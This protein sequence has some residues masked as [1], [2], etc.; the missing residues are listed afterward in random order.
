MSAEVPAWAVF[1]FALGQFGP[2]AIPALLVASAL[3]ISRYWHRCK[4]HNAAVRRALRAHS[5][6]SSGGDPL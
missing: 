5:E 4:V 3:L 6:A 1:L 2:I